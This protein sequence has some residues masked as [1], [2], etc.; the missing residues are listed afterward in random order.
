MTANQ[1]DFNGYFLSTQQFTGEIICTGNEIISGR[2]ADFN[3]RYAAARL[4]EAG[5]T[6]QSITFLGDNTFQFEDTLA[7]GL[8]RSR[9]IIIT[10]GLGPT[11]DDITAAAAASL[12]QLPLHQDEFLL[13]RLKECFKKRG[14][15]WEDRFAR[16]A[17]VPQGACILDPEAAACGFYLKH[18]DTLLYFLP[19]VP[20]EMQLLFNNYVLPRLLQ[21]AAGSAVVCQRTLRFFGLH[22]TELQRLSQKVCRLR[23]DLCVGYYPNFPENHLTLTVR[24]PNSKALE[25]ALDEVTKDLAAQAGDAYLGAVSLEENVGQLLQARK[26]TLAVAE[27]CSGGLICHR[28]T[29]VP[30]SSDYFL[31]GLVTYSN[32]AKIDFLKVPSET[33]QIYGAVSVP[34]AEA[35]ALGAAAQLH[36]DVALAVTGIAGPSGGSPEKPVGTVYLG[37]A[38]SQGVKSRHCLFHGSREEIKILTA[39]T[40]LD[41]LRLELQ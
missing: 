35:M 26:L 13:Q 25:A 18:Q 24:G 38:T 31:G 15:P 19:G 7:R 36:A 29:N 21:I 9:F 22:E 2:V 5:L 1:I 10:G 33:L 32:Q 17:L 14:L 6:V 3:A 8:S 23:A 40:A 34:T 27:S 37:L 20:R 39:Q 16:L 41:W 11:E 12:L 28:I 4:H 30:G